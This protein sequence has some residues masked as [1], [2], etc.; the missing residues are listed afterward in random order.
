[1]I[2]RRSVKEYLSLIKEKNLPLDLFEI[3][4]IED[5]FPV[6]RVYGLLNEKGEG[7]YEAE[8]F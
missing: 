6:E 5:N 4:D 8:S 7:Y 3:I 2:D 1:M